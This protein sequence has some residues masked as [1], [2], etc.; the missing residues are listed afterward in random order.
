MPRPMC[1]ERKDVRLPGELLVDCENFAA[2]MKFPSVSAFIVN[3]LEN[4]IARLNTYRFDYYTQLRPM[5][6]QLETGGVG[7]CPTASDDP[8]DLGFTVR[9]K[10]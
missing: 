10:V 6:A 3:A 8:P 4:E 7:P 9:R 2:R 5:F 1:D